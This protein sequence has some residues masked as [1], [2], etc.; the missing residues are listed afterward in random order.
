MENLG[1]Y[2]GTFGPIVEMAIPMNDRVCWFAT[3]CPVRAISTYDFTADSQ[4][5]IS[6]MRCM[7]DCPA[8][9]RKVNGL[10]VKIASAAIAK[11]CNVRKE[12]ELF[13]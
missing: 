8:H 13:L 2:T 9:A 3:A 7:C 10:M 11:E 6:C 1:Y 4:T 12:A 5:C